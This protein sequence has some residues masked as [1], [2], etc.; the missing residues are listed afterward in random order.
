ME[1]RD[2][3]GTESAGGVPHRH[4]LGCSGHLE[5][6][7]ESSWAKRCMSVNVEGR[8]ARGKPRKT[9]EEV[10]GDLRAKEIARDC[11][12]WRDAVR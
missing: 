9:W 7:E 2:W 4:R 5:S 6:M 12:G 10:L 11:Q 1:L 3:L 8:K